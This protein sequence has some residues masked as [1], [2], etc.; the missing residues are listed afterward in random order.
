ML[1]IHELHVCFPHKLKCH[2]QTVAQTVDFSLETATDVAKS[3]QLL[4]RIGLVA[5]PSGSSTGWCFPGAGAVKKRLRGY[6]WH[7]PCSQPWSSYC[8]LP[9]LLSCWDSKGLL[10]I[11]FL[12]CLQYQLYSWRVG[13]ASVDCTEGDWGDGMPYVS[14]CILSKITL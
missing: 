1:C 14:W 6:S 4:S 3:L 13:R 9:P 5:Q 7:S 8:Y 11:T 2:P 10:L 12:S